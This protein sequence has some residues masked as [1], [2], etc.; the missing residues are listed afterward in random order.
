MQYLLPLLLR[1]LDLLILAA[2]HYS[3]NRYLLITSTFEFKKAGKSNLFFS[4][5]YIVL[6]TEI[7]F[8]T[9]KH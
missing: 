2:E 7:L 8:L 1:Y 3:G 9:W 6:T 5:K 4:S